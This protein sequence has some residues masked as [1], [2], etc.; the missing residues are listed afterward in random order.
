[1]DYLEFEFT[2]EADEGD[3][4]GMED[5]EDVVIIGIDGGGT[6]IQ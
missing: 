5:E 6:G 1:M 2:K 3:E 4:D